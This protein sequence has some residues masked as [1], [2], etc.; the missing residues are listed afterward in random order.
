MVMLATA[1]LL[2]ALAWFG[3]LY[4]LHGVFFFFWVTYKNAA[5]FIFGYTIQSIT[6]AR[7]ADDFLSPFYS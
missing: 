1:A 4:Y 5:R 6:T 7:F 3:L 2:A